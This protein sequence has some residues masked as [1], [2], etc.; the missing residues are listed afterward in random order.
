MPRGFRSCA[1]FR[2]P[3]GRHRRRLRQITA[4]L[5]PAFQSLTFAAA[6]ENPWNRG[7]VAK[8]GLRALA[9]LGGPAAAAAVTRIVAGDVVQGPGLI[10]AMRAA[11]ALHC[12]LPADKCLALLRHPDPI[13]RAHAA[14]LAGPRADIIAPIVAVLVDLLQD[15]HGAV[16]RAAA[17]ALGRMG[18]GEARPMLV[19]MLRDDPSA[20][21]IDAV[22]AVADEQIVVLLGRIARTRPDLSPLATA[23]LEDIDDPRAATLTSSLREALSG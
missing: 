17:C 10:E 3:L 6:R 16:A 11:A 13:V 15:I 4:P 23:A 20:D 22:A 5:I 2:K 1:P 9:G 21:V 7:S 14:D 18:R 8:V 19:A 12:R